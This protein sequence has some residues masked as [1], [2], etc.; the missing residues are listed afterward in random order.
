MTQYLYADGDI[1][2]TN[3]AAGTWASID[4][5]PYSDADF[6]RTTAG[7]SA[8]Y[9]VSLTNPV[10]PDGTIGAIAFRAFK[11]DS[12]AV[13]K[14]DGQTVEITTRIYQGGTL[15]YSSPSSNT[16]G[17]TVTAA[18]GSAL[19]T[20]V[21]DWNDIRLRFI[22]TISGTGGSRGAAITWARVEVPD[23][24]NYTLS[25]TGASFTLTGGAVNFK[26]GLPV[27]T[28]AYA[29]GFGAV[30]FNGSVALSVDSAAYVLSV[31]DIAMS[32]TVPALVFDGQEYEAAFGNVSLT[33]FNK[34][35]SFAGY[36]PAER[37]QSRNRD[38]RSR[39][40]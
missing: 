34:T 8:V 33:I 7:S 22:V 1:T 40:R 19:F 3:I 16:L 18:S 32:Y 35:Y 23:P 30:A 28:S 24:A 9:E 38:V 20:S 26:I 2:R 4:E 31:P 25:V 36:R 39:R 10:T 13:A 29:L 17:A 12:S 5:E 15:I 37:S 14:S 21:T 11:C 27:S 6:V